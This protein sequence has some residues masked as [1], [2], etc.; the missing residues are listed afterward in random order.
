MLTPRNGDFAYVFLWILEHEAGVAR[1]NSSC[2]LIRC[3]FF[4]SFLKS[5][6]RNIPGKNGELTCDGVRQQM[7][8]Q[9]TCHVSSNTESP[10][11]IS[12]GGALLLVIAGSSHNTFAD[13]LPLFSKHVGWLFRLLGMTARLD[14]VLGAHLVNISCLNFLSNHLP[15]S[16]EQRDLQ[17]WAPSVATDKSALSRIRILKK[18]E[19]ITYSSKFS[20]ADSIR[21]LICSVSDYVLDRVLSASWSSRNVTTPPSANESA[22]TVSESPHD[23]ITASELLESSLPSSEPSLGCH[24]HAPGQPA[25]HYPYRASTKAELPSSNKENIEGSSCE[26]RDWRQLGAFERSIGFQY[27]NRVR[28]EHV[29]GYRYLL[30]SESIF[31]C[32]VWERVSQPPTSPF[33]LH[34]SKRSDG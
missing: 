11:A 21:K 8:L 16:T 25:I 4:F 19:E 9:S 28:R 7:V 6:C 32:E 33:S 23:L 31:K 30:G 14:P 20:I 13:P 26:Q 27:T 34:G 1:L 29:E 15:L 18:S 2:H 10:R 5:A 24:P 17:S 3:P 12:G 22:G